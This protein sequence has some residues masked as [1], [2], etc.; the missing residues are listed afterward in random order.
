M[1]NNKN[2]NNKPQIE[3]FNNYPPIFL[4]KTAP[5]NT[6]KQVFENLPKDTQVSPLLEVTPKTSALRLGFA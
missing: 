2:K 3:F 5:K 4:P 1:N 6:F